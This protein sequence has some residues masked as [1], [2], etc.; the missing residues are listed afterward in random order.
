M[1]ANLLKHLVPQIWGAEQESVDVPEDV[2]V[3]LLEVNR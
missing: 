3:P 2:V 1:G